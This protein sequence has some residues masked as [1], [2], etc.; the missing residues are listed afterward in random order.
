[1]DIYHLLHFV[2]MI[3]LK[4][5]V[6]FC[7]ENIIENAYRY[8]NSKIRIILKQNYLELYNDG[9]IINT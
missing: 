4:Q 8:V 2:N 5:L 7:V 3:L 6:F 9:D 1:M